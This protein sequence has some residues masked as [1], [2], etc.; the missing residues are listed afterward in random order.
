MIDYKA[1][2]WN[3]IRKNRLRKIPLIFCLLSL[4][5]IPSTLLAQSNDWHYSI[6]AQGIAT[7]NDKL[8]FW[9]RS[10]QYGSVPL[11]G[12]S[13]SLIG[14]IHRDYD[15]TKKH[16]DWA[17]GLE[18]RGNFGNGS[19]LTLIEGFIK[20]R[21][22]IFEFKGGR[23]R[24]I[25]GLV[26]SSLSTGAF[27]ISGNAL[28]IPKASISIPDYYS[29]PFF[30][31][32][33]AF[34]GNYSFGY[35]GNVATNIGNKDAYYQENEL[36]IRFGQP[37]WRLKLIGGINHHVMF[38]L[39]PKSKIPSFQ[40]ILYAGIGKTYNGY[41][42]VGNHIGSV[43]LG[44]QY[45]FDDTR[46]FIYRQN[47]YDEGALYHLANIADG[48]NG[49]SLTNKRY[50]SG[51]TNWHKFLFEFI[52][53]ANQ[54][55]YFNSIITNSGDE[56]YYNNYQFVQGWSYKGLILGNSL[57]A[58][59]KYIRKNLITSPEDY[60]I[61]NR[62]E[63]FNIGME[64]SSHDI[65]AIVKL[66][67]SQNYGTFAT[68]PEGHSLGNHHDKPIFGLFGEINQFSGYFELNKT[69]EGN[70]LVG[71]AVSGDQG[72]LYYNSLGILLK[73]RKSFQ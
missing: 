49:I 32:L 19:N 42:K 60:F 65:N 13:G 64:G 73:L 4:W 66:T 48:I 24:D 43:D 46:L 33:F 6:E 8:P 29:L 52:Y 45:E 58:D 1:M 72:N 2:L 34:K 36:Y 41:S 28:G 63:A 23:T 62:V 70:Y 59:R 16:F 68:S 35:V 20:A 10:D 15:T 30:N 17:A 7:P 50:D 57:V 26:D 11:T 38:T 31:K 22:G 71:V 67:Y 25:T 21:L 39:D 47:L 54:A 14:N 27:A 69:F 18:A 12:L 53:T 56:N 44:L 55:G 5:T 51:K 3:W 61:D 37:G 40:Q 9:L